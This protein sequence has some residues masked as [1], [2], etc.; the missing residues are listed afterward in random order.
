MEAMALISL[1]VQD[2]WAMANTIFE[3]PS[4]FPM[5]SSSGLHT[6]ASEGKM[7]ARMRSPKF[8]SFCKL[9]ETAA[10]VKPRRSWRR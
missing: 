6:E 3:F 10:E 7:E 2:C 8:L 4:T 1:A 5:T 9:F